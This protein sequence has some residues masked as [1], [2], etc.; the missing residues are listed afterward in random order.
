VSCAIALAGVLVGLAP[1]SAADHRPSTIHYFGPRTV[2]L[3]GD[4]L[5][6]ETRKLFARKGWTIKVYAY[7]G[8]APC[9]WLTSWHPNLVDLL[10]RRP[11]YLFIETAGNNSTKCMEHANGSRV[12]PGTL[13]YFYRYKTALSTI[14]ALAAHAGVRTV[15]LA[16]PP[17]TEHN[18]NKANLYLARWV[19]KGPGHPGVIV[20]YAARNAVSRGGKFALFLPCL[21]TETATTGCAA[22]VIPVR[23][24]N[25]PVHTHFCPYEGDWVKGFL[26]GAYSSG[27]HR[28]AA[29]VDKLI[30]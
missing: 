14:F 13:E 17:M 21:A 8:T 2:L 6:S 11:A 30:I 5:T 10:R 15:Y 27:E 7:P 22:G 29:A 24:V 26:C 23:T 9:D 20:S 12:Q 25:D 28:W 16:P 4:S 3:A 1:V 18:L 19:A